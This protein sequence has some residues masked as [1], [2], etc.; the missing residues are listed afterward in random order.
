MAVISVVSGAIR[1]SHSRQAE[2]GKLSIAALETWKQMQRLYRKYPD[3]W[4]WILLSQ[5]IEGWLTE[6]EAAQLF[7]LA[8]E[9]TQQGSPTVVE[10]GSWKGKSS[11]MLAGGLHGKKEAKLYCIDV[12]GEAITDPEFRQT[13]EP[14]LKRAEMPIDLC[15]KTNIQFAGLDTIVTPVRGYTNEVVKQWREP[16][17]M[18][19]IDA[20]H[21]YEA[22]L[23]DFEDWSA[24]VKPGGVVALHDV[25]EC[26]AGPARV[27][28]EKLVAPDYGPV[29]RTDSLAW[30]V[31]AAGD[32]V[33]QR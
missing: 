14:L 22:V 1:L 13:Y 24:F 3:C 7:R 20:N 32:R 11:V 31:K 5:Q 19:F 17:N 4:A 30:S 6:S 29:N 12:F 18:L 25:G 15:F 16:I 21:E 9:C 26:Y 27:V 23:A 10:L 28:E 33:N 2:R 8:R